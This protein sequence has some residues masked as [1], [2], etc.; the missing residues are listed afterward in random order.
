[1]SLIKKKTVS[2]IE[3]LLENDID[4]NSIK[5]PNKNNK[6][7]R[8]QLLELLL[9]IQNSTSLTDL[10]DGEIK[11]YTFGQSIAQTQLLHFLDG[12]MNE[13]PFEDS[14]LGIK[15][16]QEI[17]VCFSDKN[18]FKGT[19]T[20]ND[21]K[22]PSHYLKLEE[23]YKFI[24]KV[25]KKKIMNKGKLNTITGPNKLLQIR[26]KA[27]KNKKTGKYTPLIYD[28]HE[29]QNKYMAF[30]LCSNFGKKLFNH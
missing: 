17:Y 29:L 22:N 19:I 5:K 21:N 16:K 11:T 10:I 8:G 28:G 1:M 18:E 25:I 4:W 9:G 27:S 7:K 3:H 13:I 20:L 24:S 30:Y 14:K 23:D 15:M 26:T 2:E 6:G 12:I